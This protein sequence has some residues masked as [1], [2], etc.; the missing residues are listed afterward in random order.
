[1]AGYKE[2]P[3]QKMIAMM[4]LVLTALLALNVSKE[5]LDA[6]KVVNDSVELTNENFSEKLTGLHQVFDSRYAIDNEKVGPFREKAIEAR[7]LSNELRSFVENM[8]WRLIS[9][10]ERIDYDSARN[11]PLGDLKK[12]DDFTTTTNFFMRGT[13]DGSQ[14]EGI[15]LEEKINQYREDMLNLVEQRFR[16]QIKIGLQTDGN[17]TDRDGKPLNWIQY[18]FYNTVLAANLTILNKII[19]EIHNAE[20]DVVNHL[21]SS[22]DAADFK[23]DAVFA[24][25]LQKRDYVLKGDTYEAEIVVAAYSTTQNP[26]VYILEGVDRLAPDQ[27]SRARKYTGAAGIVNYQVPAQTEG[28]K[29]YAGIVRLTNPLGET[30]D[31]HFSSQ[32]QVAEPTT[33]V[34]ATKMNVFYAGVDNPIS[35]SSPG[36]PLENLL[37]E[38]STGQVTPDN[39]PGHYIV[40]VP[41]DKSQ[42]VVTVSARIGG[43]IRKQG[44]K[45][46]RIKNVPDPIAQIAGQREGQ[47]NRNVLARTN[48]I[49]ARMP[50]D[51]EFDMSFTVASFTMLIARGTIINTYTS[52]SNRI[53]NEMSNAIQNANRGDRVWFENIFA[54]G[55]DG[56]NRSLNNISLTIN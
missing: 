37:V 43:Q 24:R 8:K 14:G 25:V 30:E 56:T 2:T 49:E 19:T 42:A 29:R 23:H 20:F 54:R 47:I 34:S 31:F 22:I 10:V 51:F 21:L 36:I 45:E 16:N 4:Y 6:F 41:A 53:T 1:M 38:I 39:R 18:N 12:L 28:Q 46:Y 13:V 35:I 40:K 44:D 9:A 26:E 52:S 7:E 17:Y 27:I 55:E 33:T 50:A 48:A 3:R 11:T 5:V 32:Y 15:V